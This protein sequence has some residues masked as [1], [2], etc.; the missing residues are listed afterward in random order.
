MGSPEQVGGPSGAAGGAARTTVRQGSAGGTRGPRG[1]RGEP[2]E[3]QGSARGARGEP[4]QPGQPGQSQGTFEHADA[5]ELL[6]LGRFIGPRPPPLLLLVLVNGHDGVTHD[7]HLGVENGGTSLKLGPPLT[8]APRPLVEVWTARARLLSVQSSQ[9]AGGSVRGGWA[10]ELWRW[11]AGRLR[12]RAFKQA[13]A[14]V[15]R[16]SS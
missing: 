5:Q 12:S 14:R 3:P 7:V 6:L 10:A 1:A 4:G 11:A 8:V 15:V 13:G 2:G 9:A 16:P